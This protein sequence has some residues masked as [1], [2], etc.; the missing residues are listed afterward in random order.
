M[1][2]VGKYIDGLFEQ[3]R[4]PWSVLNNVKLCS[5]YEGKSFINS[6]TDC[7]KIAISINEDFHKDAEP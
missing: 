3:F 5:S 1:S 2:S 7:K 4:I 6:T